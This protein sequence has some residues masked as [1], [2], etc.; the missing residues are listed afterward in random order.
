MMK[1]TVLR[2]DRERGISAKVFSV[3]HWAVVAGGWY[4]VAHMTSTQKA[5]A[6]AA[7]NATASHR[8]QM[9]CFPLTS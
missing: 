1:R 9:S 4:L 8:F 2:M 7:R 3:K 5:R 6:A